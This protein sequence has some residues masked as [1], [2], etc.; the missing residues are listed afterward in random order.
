MVH[1]VSQTHDAQT[2]TA[3]AQGGFLELGHSGDVGVGIDDIIQEAGGQ[4]GI[5]AQ[6]VP[7]HGMVGAEMLGEV[8]GA[9]A[10]VLVGSEPL[11]TAGIGGFKLVE[12]RDGV[13]AVGGI[14]EEQTGLTVV[15]RLLDD[16]LEQVAG[17]DGFV[18]AEGDAL[19]FSLFKGAFEALGARVEQVGE[20]QCPLAVFFDGG[21]EGIGDAHGDIEVGDLSS[22]WSCR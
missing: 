13:G 3:G 6:L 21:H 2:D 12:V 17:A 18:N 11:L 10:A 5:L 7:I 22:R 4:A 20:A 15:M 8:D 14:Q 1:Q 16:L 19:G 9:E